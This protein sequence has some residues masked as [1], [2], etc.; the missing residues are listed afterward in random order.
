MIRFRVYGIPQTKGSTRAFFRPGMRYPVIT[1]DNPKNKSWALCVS[2]EAVKHRP[3]ALLLGPVRLTLVFHLA[4][5]KSLPKRKPSW[6]VKK[7]D[8]SKLTRSAEDALTGIIWR[9]DSQVV[10]ST[11]RKLYSDV[12]GVE[13]QIE[14]T[15]D[16]QP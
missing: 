5:P 1:N 7:P 12:P 6:P 9:D 16:K 14:P 8:L 11:Q 10:E 15:E 4:K 3:S 2:E 13:I